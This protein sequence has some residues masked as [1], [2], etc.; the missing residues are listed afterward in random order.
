MKA[1]KEHPYPEDFEEF[2]D[3]FPTESDCRDYLEWVRWSDGFVC[4][5]CGHTACWKF[6]SGIRKC[7]K[8][9]KL[10][11]VTNGTVFDSG[12]KSMRLWFHVMWLLM[13]QKTGISAQNFCDM[14][15]FG[16][17]Q[18]TWGWLQKLRSVMIRS[19]RDQLTGR[20]EVDETY[21]GGQKEGKRG[22]GA[23]SKTLVLVAVE[24]DK[25][26]KLG[27]VRFKIVKTHSSAAIKT[28]VSDYVAPGSTV[29]TDGLK[30]YNFF[31]GLD[32]KH[33][34]YVLSQGQPDAD[35]NLEHVHLVISLVKRWML[36]TLQGAVTPDH[37]SGYL[38]EFA[39]RFNR[40]MSTHRG[41]LFHRLV[42]QAITA[43]PKNIKEL[44][45][46]RKAK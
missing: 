14:F 4:P 41:K 26:A 31:D 11:S 7:A 24:G 8:C 37:M 39:F 28:F 32:V 20:V 21:I 45:N 35:S 46:H 44:Y 36:G 13:A 43:R 38:D 19:G 25:G 30:S 6:E 16:S 22:R 15:G 27:R 2:L 29:V 10:I 34:P 23:A 17:Y 3:W 12:K 18:T 1:T 40:R 42:Q 33:E 5:K 9:R